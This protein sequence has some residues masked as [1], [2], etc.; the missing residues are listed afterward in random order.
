MTKKRSTKMKKS[1]IPIAVYRDRP[2]KWRDL[3]L[4]FLPATLVPVVL[5]VIGYSRERY[6]LMNYGPVAAETWSSTWYGFALVSLI[7][8]V[9]L[10]LI[11]I[12][13]SHRLIK[14]YNK[15][16]IIQSTWGRKWKLSFSQILGI[17]GV[18]T[19]NRLF[20]IP[21]N[22]RYQAQLHLSDD[23]IIKL[24]HQLKDLEELCARVKAKIY[25]SLLKRYRAAF[26]G[27]DTISFGPI[28]MNTYQIAINNLNIPWDRV[29]NIEIKGG[30]LNIE[31]DGNRKVKIGIRKVPN[32]EIFLQIIQESVTYD[33]TKGNHS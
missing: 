6:G 14:V 17:S 25:P 27:D 7:P 4:L 1:L 16:L 23:K 22:T 8:L 11:R 29:C 19:Q 3:I 33:R 24:D 20:S 32:I 31:Y 13:R 18:K 12:R 15:G 21:I 5:L 26:K 10:L 2:L 30:V 9:G 28:L